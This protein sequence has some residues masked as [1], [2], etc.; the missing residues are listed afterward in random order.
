MI[1]QKHPDL[2]PDHPH[3]HLYKTERINGKWGNGKFVQYWCGHDGCQQPLGWQFIDN[4]SNLNGPGRCL[5]QSIPG[6][7]DI[8][9]KKEIALFWHM[10]GFVGAFVAI[11]ML[12]LIWAGLDPIGRAVHIGI[13]I[14]FMSLIPVAIRRTRKLDK[15]YPTLRRR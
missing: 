6:R 5:D 3:N 9:N 2:C 7:I 15:N 11:G 12:V 8:N 14:A 10:V 1:A 13:I 4:N